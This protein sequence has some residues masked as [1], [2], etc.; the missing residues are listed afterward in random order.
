MK[1]QWGRWHVDA[2]N[3][4]IS[5]LNSG[6]L[7]VFTIPPRNVLVP[8][9]VLKWIAGSHQDGPFSEDDIRDLVMALAD[10][11]GMAQESPG[12]RYPDKINAGSSYEKNAA[13]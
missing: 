6:L 11:F 7:Q 4:T 10:L 9:E 12:L 13:P 3:L 8:S 2:D 1:K 5:Y